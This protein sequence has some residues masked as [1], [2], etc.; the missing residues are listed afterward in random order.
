MHIK[1]MRSEYCNTK[2]D[3]I[4]TNLSILLFPS[5][6]HSVSVINMCNLPPKKRRGGKKK[7][8]VKN[9]KETNRYHFTFIIIT[10]I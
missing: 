10:E 3:L 2:T 8:K 7:A 9:H 1:V 5:Y 4:Q 6:F